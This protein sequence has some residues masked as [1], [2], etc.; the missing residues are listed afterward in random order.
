ML[1]ASAGAVGG[2]VNAYFAREGLVR[3]RTQRLPSGE[4][5]W[6]PG[7]L[8]NVGIGAIT[9]L[10]LAGLYSPLALVQI[11]AETGAYQLTVGGLMGA[12]LSGIGGARLLTNEVNRRFEGI[13]RE[14][15]TKALE[16]W[17]KAKND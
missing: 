8:G 10:V 9:A 7:F 14:Q 2:L 6:Q 16:E 4:T 1:I 12:L 11:G 15:L 13:T 5:V 3:W 17:S